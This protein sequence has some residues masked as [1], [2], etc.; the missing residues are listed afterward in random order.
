[1]SIYI[2]MYTY[3]SASVCILFRPRVC[4]IKCIID[5]ERYALN[6]RQAEANT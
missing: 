2:S 3:T 4:T 6:A 5:V 1:M